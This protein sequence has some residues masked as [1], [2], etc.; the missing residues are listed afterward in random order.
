MVV[1]AADRSC[2]QYTGERNVDSRMIYALP[3]NSTQQGCPVLGL[4]P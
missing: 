4:A 3:G 1:L 2:T